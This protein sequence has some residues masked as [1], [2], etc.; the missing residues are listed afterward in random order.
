MRHLVAGEPPPPPQSVT[1]PPSL[2]TSYELCGMRHLGGVEQNMELMAR[3]V[4]HIL[5]MKKYE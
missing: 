3:L 4:I 2:L 1:L 5:N